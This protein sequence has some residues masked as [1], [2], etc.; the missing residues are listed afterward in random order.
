[1]QSSRAGPIRYLLEGPAGAAA[2]TKEHTDSEHPFQA[3]G[4]HF[5]QW[6]IPHLVGDGEHTA[7]REVN[8]P[9]SSAVRMQRMTD[10]DGRHP[11][12]GKNSVV[13]G[14]GQRSKEPIVE[15]SSVGQSAERR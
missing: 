9:D 1:M 6:P 11:Q 2:I 12:V 7:V 10:G 15:Q 4:G 3:D 8:I 14:A 5:Y 13:V